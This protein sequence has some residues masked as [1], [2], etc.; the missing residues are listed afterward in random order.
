MERICLLGEQI[1]L[2]ERIC[3]LG[4]ADTHKG[5]NLPS[6][7]YVDLNSGATKNSRVDQHKSSKLTANLFQSSTLER[8]SHFVMRT[9]CRIKVV[10]LFP[11]TCPIVC[12]ASIYAR[13]EARLK[14]RNNAYKYA[15]VSNISSI[16]KRSAFKCLVRRMI[17]ITIKYIVTDGFLTVCS[18]HMCI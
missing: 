17:I 11:S 1:H 16:T 8:S 15:H 5:K 7:L 6:S 4:R 2:M 9:S 10:N 12:I 14:K 13:C 3:P 18:D